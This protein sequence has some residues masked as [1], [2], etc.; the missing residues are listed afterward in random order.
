MG[1]RPA[2]VQRSARRP[3]G[4]L[5]LTL[6]LVALFVSP[7]AS[8]AAATLNDR[9]AAG[10]KTTSN[11]GKDRMLLQAQEMIYDRDHNRVEARGN[12]QI[13]YQGRVLQGDRVVY[14]RDTQR[15]HAEGHAKL[16]ERDGSV[17]YGDTIEVT[18]NFKDGFIDSLRT[19]SADHTYLTAARGERSGGESTVLNDATYTACEP[20]KA[21]PSKPPFWQIRAKRIVHDNAE[22]VVYFE[23]AT[24]EL[25]G[26]PIAYLPYLSA[27]DPSVTRKSGV[28]AP[29]YTTG[30]YTGVGVTAPVFWAIA[31]N[32]DLTVS[33]T[34]YTRQGF[35]GEAEWRHKLVNGAYDI[36]A[37]GILQEDPGAFPLPP[38]GAGDRRGRGSI[39]SWGQFYINDKW[40]YGWDVTLLSDRFFLQDYRL[41][42]D[43]VSSNY[44]REATSTLYLTG[45]SDRGYF[46]LRSY[47]FEGLSSADIQQQQ[48]VVAPVLDYNKTIDLSP[49]ATFGIGGQI[50]IDANVT[51][52][53]RDLA[54]YE[55]TG[56][57][58]LDST[59]NLYDVCLTYTRSACTVRGIG[60]DY[61]RATLN[62]S[63]KRQFIDPI[64]QVWT[65]F[66]FTRVNGTMLSLNENNVFAPTTI[67]NA[68]QSNFFGGQ[69]GSWHGEVIPGVGLEYRYPFVLAN[70]WATQIF[71]PIA[72]V[73]V[74]PNE[75]VNQALVNEDSQ[76]LVFDDTNLFEWNKFSGYD[77]FEGGT[78]ANYGGQYT[79]TFKNGGYVNLLVGQSFQIA[80]RNSYATP[81]AAN[82]GLSSGLN[83]RASD[84][85]TRFS[86][87]PNSQFA[88]I[89]KARFDPSNYGV[90]RL[91]LIGSGK[92]TDNLDAVVQY[93]DYAAQPL[94][95][96]DVRRQGLSTSL[97]YK[98]EQH[99]FT[100]G[101][102]I[103]DLSRHLYSSTG[104]IAGR[105]ALFSLAGLGVGAGYTDDCTTVSVNY[106]SVYEDNGTGSP[107]RNQTVLLQ[108]Q[109]RT[110]GDTRLQSNLNDIRVQDGLTNASSYTVN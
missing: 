70:D 105:A 33:P 57:R 66:A 76:S 15:V 96:Y 77:R 78:R 110:L 92:I 38:Y 87:A 68:N 81:D 44:F 4:L 85:V 101:N 61:A 42:L 50:E 16:T 55:S 63:W 75:P 109:F 103:F 100:S 48:P 80:G 97:K 46:D 40:R 60:G 62:A 1:R 17:V 51:N 7:I 95:G 39:E 56:V 71:E 90:R 54:A 24:F 65:P 9:I 3:C 43:M 18:D 36:R 67:A 8:A 29:R 22:Q 30:N 93:A 5:A 94:I 41:P 91:D 2:P 73:I 82:I 88:F 83:T 64:G 45:Q 52:I 74:R 14:D 10:E 20:C 99:Y 53:K 107:V 89:A 84:I 102:V 11:G 79:M 6:V 13:Y 37:A 23:D 21:N 27:P 106:T 104:L 98:F 69:T 19:D 35:F 58:T 32:Y 72:Q 28:L 31:P 108:L 26:V 34:F 49:K 25:M 12:V 47:Y 59:Y 86:V